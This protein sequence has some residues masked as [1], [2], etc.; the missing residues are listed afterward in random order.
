MWWCCLAVAWAGGLDVQVLP[1]LPTERPARRELARAGGV[2]V[3]WVAGGLLIDGELERGWQSV[4][5]GPALLIAP[6]AVRAPEARVRVASTPEALVLA[7]EGLEAGAVGQLVVDAD[8]ARRLWWQ[9]RVG[10]QVSW[11]RCGLDETL[12]AYLP[13]RAVPCVAVQRP[14]WSARGAEAW[15]VAIPWSAMP[16]A[17]SRMRLLW[18]VEQGGRVAGSWANNGDLAVLPERG[19]LLRAPQPRGR[20]EVVVD[21]QDGRW[22]VTLR[23]GE[24]DRYRWRWTRTDFGQVVDEG[25]VPGG[26]EPSWELP[27][28]VSYGGAI[29]LRAEVTDPVA[30]G[31]V[32]LVGRPDSRARVISPVYR[33][34]I[35]LAW[36]SGEAV[37]GLELTVHD[38][39]GKL[40]GEALV[41]LP[42]GRGVLRVKAGRRWGAVTV[43]L[44]ALMPGGM[45]ATRAP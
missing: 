34:A 2:P 29:S 28:L 7:I 15:E 30:P 11:E 14:A 5:P 36:E 40:L 33:D 37:S 13:S 25:E 12:P 24:P 22:R 43:R 39:A 38:A 19:A 20:L 26:A 9:A 10:E 18:T 35:T 45:V 8:G 21:P 17:T 42:A 1:D 32:Q 27:P 4:K 23:E 16:P 31:F 41:D 44:A 3:T 6:D